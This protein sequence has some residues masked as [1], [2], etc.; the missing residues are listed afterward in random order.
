MTEVERDILTLEEVAAYLKA[1][2]GRSTAS[3]RKER[4][5]LSSWGGTWRFRRSELDRWI[6]DSI[7]KKKLGEK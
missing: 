4:F 7:S 6:A 3:L 5:R 1:G 2:N